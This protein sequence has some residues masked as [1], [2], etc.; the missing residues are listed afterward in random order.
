L[1]ARLTGKRTALPPAGV[2]GVW[3]S[4]RPAVTCC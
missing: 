2:T 3:R 4:P 1:P